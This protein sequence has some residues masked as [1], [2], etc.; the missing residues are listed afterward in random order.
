MVQRTGE[1]L[2]RSPNV[3]FAIKT[4]RQTNHIH[5]EV[6]HLGMRNNGE[7]SLVEVIDLSSYFG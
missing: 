7:G 1:A 3:V 5:V 2:Q 4:K 6:L